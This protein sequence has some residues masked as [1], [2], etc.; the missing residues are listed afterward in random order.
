MY[1]SGMHDTYVTLSG[2]QF[3]Q[4]YIYLYEDYFMRSSIKILT[5]VAESGLQ[6][7]KFIILLENKSP[8]RCTIKL[9]KHCPQKIKQ[10][11]LFIY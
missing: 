9:I 8:A 3:K 6:F 1:F 11:Y 10:K 7:N 2:L 4:F 5:Y